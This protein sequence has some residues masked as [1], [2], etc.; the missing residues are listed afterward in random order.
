MPW[1]NQ[2]FEYSFYRERIVNEWM[3]DEWVSER[4]II[5]SYR[6]WKF[7]D[8]HTTHAPPCHSGRWPTGSLP[9][10]TVTPDCSPLHFIYLSLVVLLIFILYSI[11]EIIFI[12]VFIVNLI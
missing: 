11:Y 3:I 4:M 1:Q 8:G 9:S 2:T 7:I 12:Y 6:Y 5:Q 10:L